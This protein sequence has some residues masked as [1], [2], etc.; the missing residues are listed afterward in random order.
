MLIYMRQLFHANANMYYHSMFSFGKRGAS[1][2][3]LIKVKICRV[4]V[5][6]TY[7]HFNHELQ[8]QDKI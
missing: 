6:T 8:V 2:S 5:H 3:N 1:R 7:F 4:Y